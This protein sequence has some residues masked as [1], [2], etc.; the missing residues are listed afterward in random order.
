MGHRVWRVQLAALMLSALA[1]P[2]QPLAAPAS[3]ESQAPTRL[4]LSRQPSAGTIEAVSG[5][6]FI[7]RRNESAWVRVVQ[8]N[9]PFDMTDVIRTGPDGLARVRF[10]DRGPR[11][12]LRGAFDLGPG[13]DLQPQSAEDELR[14]LPDVPPRGR[15]IWW[16]VRGAVRMFLEADADG[17]RPLRF[18][19]VGPTCDARP[20]ETRNPWIVGERGPFEPLLH[21]RL[22][23]RHAA[24]ETTAVRQ[25]RAG[26]G[27]L[28]SDLVAQVDEAQAGA[29]L[30]VRYGE[31]TC[32]STNRTGTTSRVASGELVTLGADGRM[33][34]ATLDAGRWGQLT[35]RTQVPGLAPLD[36]NSTPSGGPSTG[37]ALDAGDG[38]SVIA[39]TALSGA[40]DEMHGRY[41]VAQCKKLCTA[42]PWCRSFDYDKA[43]QWCNLSRGSQVGGTLRG[44][45]A[46]DF[47][48]V[49]E[50]VTPK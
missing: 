45:A 25:L 9:T 5:E 2:W 40:N 26:G 41:T 43:G 17:S 44:D 29:V 38:F 36:A 23:L 6:V 49:R 37:G 24:F 30:A 19:G 22:A 18:G 39:N 35:A 28:R 8:P 31:L 42:R 11:S 7:R 48:Y 10:V 12:V 20:G 4:D 13:T 34:R 15:L 50:R 16:L 47:Y 14:R 21:A 1:L 3:D 32:R 27:L 46:W 33:R